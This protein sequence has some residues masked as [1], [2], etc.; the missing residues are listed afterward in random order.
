MHGVSYPFLSWLR[1]V[2]ELAGYGCLGVKSANKYIW[3]QKTRTAVDAEQ[4]SC[5]LLMPCGC[6]C[7]SHLP[8]PLVLPLEV[9]TYVLCMFVLMILVVEAAVRKAE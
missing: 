2:Y 3:T 4:L 6:W 8:V 9:R 1:P 5:R 7:W